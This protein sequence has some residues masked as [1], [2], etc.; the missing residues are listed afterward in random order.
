MRHPK[1]LSFSIILCFLSI[2]LFSQ[3]FLHAD[4]KNIVDG[5][6]ENFI[7]RGIG[8][9]NWMIQEGYMMQTSGIAGTQ[10]EFTNKLIE[11]IGEA[12]TD[13]F[14]TSWLHNHM[15]KVD[16]DSMAAWGFNS[17]RVAL[18]YKWFTLPIE[19][20][21]VQG[22]QTWLETG[23]IILD[24]LLS[25]CSENKMYLI[26]DMHGAPGGQ[27]A[28][29]EISDYDST[30]PSLWESEDNK[31]KLVLLWQKLAERYAD[32]PWIG[33]YDL[34]NETNWTFPQGNNSQMRSLYG[35]ITDSIRSVDNNHIIYIEGNSFANDHSGLTPPWDNNMVYSFHKYWSYNNDNSLDWI[36]NL[37][38]VYNV[39][40]WLGESG[41]NSNTWFTNL[42]SLAERKN[43]G[44]S[45]WPV[46]KTGNNN[47]LSV[48]TNSDYTQLINYW[49]GTAAKPTVDAAFQAVLKFSDNHKFENCNIQYDVIDA[50]IRQPH[51][52]DILPF[53]L[54]DVEDYIF[55]S[56]YAL[57]R[58]GYAYFDNDTA[59][60]HLETNS[61]QAW[62]SGWQYRSDGVDIEKCNDSDATNGYSVGWTSDGEWMIYTLH[63]DSAA[64]YDCVI[65]NASGGSGG[66]IVIEANG[67]IVSNEAILPSTGGWGIWRST[68]I[69]DILLPAGDIQLKL[70]NTK[71]GSNL[72]YI[73][74]INPRPAELASFKALFCETSYYPE[75]IYLNLNRDIS[76]SSMSPQDFELLV[77]NVKTNISSA[78]ISSEHP[79][80]IILKSGTALSYKNSLKLNYIGSSIY[81]NDLPL[82][83]FQG[84][85]INNKL[86]KQFDLPA[87]IQAEDFFT[88]KGLVLED[89]QDI[90]GGFN[91]GYTNA[92]DYLDYLINVPA[93]GNY[94]LDFRVA[95]LYGNARIEL[96]Y[97]ESGSYISLSN[98]TFSSTGGWQTWQTQSALVNLPAGKY[99]FRILIK[100]GEHN[101]NWINFSSKVSVEEKRNEFT[102][103]LYP[104]PVDEYLSV[105]FPE[106]NQTEKVLELYD[107]CGSLIWKISTHDDSLI[108]NAQNWKPGAYF[109]KIYD[110]ATIST[111]KLLVR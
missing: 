25:W 49:K 12:K 86:A 45:W 51:T 93:A 87:K 21:L 40:L 72:N 106:S 19:E 70:I 59:D 16:V 27:G 67:K 46:K 44:W 68:T 13:S 71:G 22:E 103:N 8:T 98:V 6:G 18:H 3:G 1:K 48:T 52:T 64:L 89:C 99:F 62:N 23:F 102:P 101:L 96:L 17:I 61:F 105:V 26:L 33:G 66:R 60:Y 75:E 7:L 91:T 107:S 31:T 37:R 53:K 63:A 55:T 9:G 56:D 65:R 79:N 80:V 42:V 90:G 58:N 110:S 95:S 32:E 104:N 77:N 73:K 97:E 50:L 14:Y 85:A 76:S 100:S 15:Q 108:L 54:F 10:H 74:F 34:I 39:P 29:A 43:I 69:T 30:K 82:E 94:Q 84:L 38:N 11:T 109:L 35:R 4:G 78:E 88:N 41:E 2:N 28:N 47:I 83:N 5:S 36:I 111:H 81:S 24:S 92:G 57:G 20:E